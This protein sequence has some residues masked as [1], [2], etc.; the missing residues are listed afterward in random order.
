MATERC[1][2]FCFWL[3]VVGLLSSLARPANEAAAQE[4]RLRIG[5]AETGGHELL[6]DAAGR[7][8]RY[9]VEYAT[10]LAKSHWMPLSAGSG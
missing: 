2:Q 1:D 5:E 10:D 7:Q 8:A 6:W 9:T 3:V 4:Y